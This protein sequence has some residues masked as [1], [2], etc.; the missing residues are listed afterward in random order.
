M[1]HSGMLFNPGPSLKS[2]CF[3]AAVIYFVMVPVKVM[4]DTT[5]DCGRFYLKTNPK[6][7]MKECVNK[8]GPRGNTAQQIR[9]SQRAVSRLLKQA[10]SLIRQEK[11]SQDQK[12]RVQRILSEARQR[13]AELQ[14][15][16]AAL[17]Q[18]QASRDQA[19]ATAQ[20]Q[21]TRAQQEQSRRLEQQQKD[22]TRQLVSQQRQLLRSLQRNNTRTDTRQTQ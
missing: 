3:A 10:E 15:Q 2:C 19:L 5:T 16:T 8:K 17:R 1:L 22:L 18:E 7:G 13:V 4:A 14:R 6:T 11:L 9:R 21:R 20:S 12:Q